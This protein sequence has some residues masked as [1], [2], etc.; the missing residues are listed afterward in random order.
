MRP[1]CW[2]LAAALA[3]PPS[4]P[5]D[6]AN[7]L[8]PL[9][10]SAGIVNS[11]SGLP[12]ALAPNTIATIYGENLSWTTRGITPNDVQNGIL[13]T[14]L[15]GAGVHVLIQNIP[16]YPLYVS[17]N[18]VNL[19][20]PNHLLP[21]KVQLQLVRDGLA[22]RQVELTLRPAAPAL[23]L[24]D[25][26]TAVAN[27]LDGSLLT[28]DNPALPGE[29]VILWATGLGETKPNPPPGRLPMQ[30]APLA[31]LSEFRIYLDRVPVSPELIHYAGVA[32]RFAG[33]YQINLFL[34][35]TVGPGPEIR[36]ALGDDISPPGIRLP[37]R[38]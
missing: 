10:S 29:L 7:P 20:I 11:A 30:A 8:A 23:F 17:P 37:V 36:L 24:L 22:G 28:W 35:D 25:A 6:G 16:A 1:T 32:P 2:L 27:R 21:G 33:L 18:Q 9:Y 13:P 26:E 31:R 19:I 3:V 34:P 4:S 15:P 12:F 14:V 5:E 38:P